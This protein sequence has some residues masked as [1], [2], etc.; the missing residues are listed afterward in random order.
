[1]HSAAYERHHSTNC[2]D[3]PKYGHKSAPFHRPYPPLLS[4][5]WC[6]WRTNPPP[7]PPKITHEPL[8]HDGSTSWRPFPTARPS[9][10]EQ[11][12]VLGDRRTGER[13]RTF[14]RWRSSSPWSCSSS[15]WSSS[16]STAA[17]PIRSAVYPLEQFCAP[18][19][20]DGWR[21]QVW[22]GREGNPFLDCLSPPM[23]IGGPIWTARWRIVFHATVHDVVHLSV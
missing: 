17:E 11:F 16:S 1:M 12:C 21:L 22:R 19:P 10:I 5:S 4:Q 18:F 23:Q 2:A 9:E 6:P 13:T 3:L 20:Y 8:S 15:P 14:L 7:H